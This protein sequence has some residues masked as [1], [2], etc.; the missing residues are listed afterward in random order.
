MSVALRGNLRDFGV[1]EVFQLIGQQRKT[2]VL[3]V[4]NDA[5]RIHVLFD[6]GGVV[7]AA[8]VRDQ[9]DVAVGELLVRRGQLGEDA[10][11]R[12]RKQCA[13]SLARLGPHLVEE[14]LVPRGELEATED[15]LTRETIFDL[16][17]HHE[18]SFHFT[19]QP[20]P[21]ERDPATLLNAEQILMDGLRMVDEWR[22]LARRLPPED[23]VL[24]RRKPFESWAARA[25]GEAR[26]RLVTAERVYLLVD[27]RVT[28]RRVI[29]L[30]RLGTFEASR[31][32][33]DL[34][35][36]GVIE[37]EKRRQTPV[38]RA[39]PGERSRSV[40]VAGVAVLL[41][42]A[43]TAL[44]LHAGAGGA[45]HVPGRLVLDPLEALDEGFALRR[46]RNAL[47]AFHVDRGEWPSSLDDL[48]KAGLLD[49]AALTPR[50]GRPYYY[51]R[52]ADGIVLLAPERAFPVAAPV[53]S[54]DAGGAG[55]AG[56]GPD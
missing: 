13:V 38:Q 11:E 43:A 5:G 35:A 45:P 25:A 29:D 27:G 42:L 4:S 52:N 3:E 22:A 50:S 56:H 15:F 24:R 8:P 18:G 26:A 6:A 37:P 55:D 16:L 33:V 32:L 36:A 17:R 49:P 9:A 14:G 1:G 48:V 34:L 10:L 46:V 44:A 2:G 20:V 53:A 39:L 19:A 7:A 28:L 21:H 47:E 12:A 23:A 51:R 41:L 54:G 31:L 30:S 40:Q